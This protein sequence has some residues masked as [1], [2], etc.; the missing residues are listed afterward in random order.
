M[1]K[2]YNKATL[3]KL[4]ADVEFQRLVTGDV[5]LARLFS[6]PRRSRDD[7]LLE[8]ALALGGVAEL[9]DARIPAP[10]PGVMMILAVLDSP[11]LSPA[12][13]SPTLLDVDVALWVFVH[14]KEALDGVGG[15]ED[16]EGKA[17]GCC[18]VAQVDRVE[19]WRLMSEMVWESFRGLERIPSN[20]VPGQPV[21]F[22]LGWFAE[23]TSRIAEAA[24]VSAEYAGWDM[25]LALGVH[26]LV[27]LHR[28]NGGKTY[29][30]SKDD[31][32]MA[33]LNQ[34]MDIRIAEKGY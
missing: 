25:P 30:P 22:G 18:D 23:T 12:T 28:K 17:A 29:D 26:Y 16:I 4:N 10:P 2:Q 21:K 32:V 9:G 19:A 6:A 24:G 20:G 5:E 27:A 8:L 14:R 1:R 34:L 7:R 31:L 11:L 15:C 13:M 33:R 3:D